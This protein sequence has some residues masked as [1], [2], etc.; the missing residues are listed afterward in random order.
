MM[1][2]HSE[3]FMLLL[4]EGHLVAEMLAQ[5]VS[6]INKVY[7]NKQTLYYMVFFNLSIGFERLLKLILITHKVYRNED[8]SYDYIKKL[9]H[10][11]NTLQQDVLK[12]TELYSPLSFDKNRISF[13][14]HNAIINEL[15]DFANRTRYHNLDKL[16]QK[17]IFDP[18]TSWKKNVIK[19]I[20]ENDIKRYSLSKEDKELASKLDAC[21][22]FDM[23]NIASWKD[24]MIQSKEDPQIEKFLR[25]YIMQIIREYSQLLIEISN[26]GWEERN[27]NIPY[28]KEIFCWLVQTDSWYKS[29]KTYSI[30]GIK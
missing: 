27:E 30:Y 23:Q 7:K 12:I 25:L 1:E 9:G 26:F 21:T 28:F 4:N 6:W 24:M 19:Y 16:G 2:K 5:G 15:N 29:H 8:I 18:I 20:Q 17:N 22:V 13:P 11:L 10:K 3:K 14:I